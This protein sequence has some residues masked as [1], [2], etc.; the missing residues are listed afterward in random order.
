MRIL[1]VGAGSM[2]S[3]LG[4]YL[5]MDHELDV[6]DI[7]RSRSE[8]L[9][10]EIG[11]MSLRDLRGLEEYDASLVCVSISGTSRVVSLLS[12]RMKSGSIIMEISSVKSPVMNS[13]KE[14]VRKGMRA[15]S[16]HPLFGPGLRDISKGKAALVRISNVEEEGS[17]ASSIFPFHLIPVEMGEHDRAMAWLALIHLMLRTFLKSSNM[18]AELISKLLSTTSS[19]FLDLAVASLTQSDELTMELMSLNPYFPE[20]FERFISTLMRKDAVIGETRWVRIKDPREAYSS[21]YRE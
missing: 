14:A 13:L 17:I 4:S 15:V 9:A 1:L 5:S 20:V 12:E 18:D 7:D 6:Y 21:L 11:G 10:R 2:G 3:L 8:K 16:L 19:R